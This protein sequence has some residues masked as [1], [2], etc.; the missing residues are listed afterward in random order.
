MDTDDVTPPES[1]EQILEETEKKQVKQELENNRLVKTNNILDTQAEITSR[2]IENYEVKNTD[3]Q[4]DDKIKGLKDELQQMRDIQQKNLQSYT[5]VLEDMPIIPMG[6]NTHEKN[7]IGFRDKAVGTEDNEHPYRVVP[8]QIK[9]SKALEADLKRSDKS[10]GGMTASTAKL[11]AVRDAWNNLSDA[12]RDLIPTLNITKAKASMKSVGMKGNQAG[13]WNKSDGILTVIIND[14]Y[15]SSSIKDQYTV[16]Q[17]EA[18]HAEWNFLSETNP[19]KTQKF[20]D[21]IMSDEMKTTPVTSYASK[22]LNTDELTENLWQQKLKKIE[23]QNKL[24]KSLG[25]DKMK[26]V[27][28]DTGLFKSYSDDEIADRKKQ[29]FKA[30]EEWAKTIYAN[31]THSALSEIVHGTST[32]MKTGLSDS[33]NL[34]KYFK[35]WE[36]LHTD[37]GT[38]EKRNE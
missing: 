7:K 16:I 26:D 9:M 25:I 17:H 1:S 4:F 8:T 34:K 33:P 13:N 20:V 22:Y 37:F 30:H 18:G 36:E 29:F 35:A 23:Q 11:V 15:R 28:T 3:G 19:K 32:R 31:E 14:K 5:D 38:R 21:T 12:Q 10:V 24:V 2:I 6:K 27:P